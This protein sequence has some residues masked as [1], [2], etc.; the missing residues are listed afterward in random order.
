M[1]RTK[2][3]VRRREKN[4]LDI[5]F[6]RSGRYTQISTSFDSVHIEAFG[7]NSMMSVM[8]MFQQPSCDAAPILLIR[9]STEKA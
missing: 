2:L 1:S 7:W 5:P 8:A 6:Y 9:R 4:V 3:A